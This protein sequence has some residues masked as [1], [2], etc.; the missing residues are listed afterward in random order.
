M[1]SP[2]GPFCPDGEQ[3]ISH[4]FV[5]CSL[6][7]LAESFGNEF[8]EWYRSLCKKKKKHSVTA[9]TEYEILYGVLKGSSSLQILNHLI[10]TGKYF[11]FICAKDS[12]KYQFAD[13][14][15][16]VREK[17]RAKKIYRHT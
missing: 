8:T 4:L 16:S 3:S 7:S 12:K 14:V 10:L 9:L 5:D 11:L 6:T 1:D 13:F 17:N 2:I 15:V